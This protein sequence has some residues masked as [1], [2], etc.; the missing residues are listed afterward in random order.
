MEKKQVMQ[1][2]HVG[3]I[4]S[5]YIYYE[6]IFI[7]GMVNVPQSTSFQFAVVL[8]LVDWTGVG[9]GNH[10]LCC[11]VVQRAVSFKVLVY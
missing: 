3:R 8:V 5:F 4:L 9:S 7:Y 6:N 2:I 10:L 1:V 11:L